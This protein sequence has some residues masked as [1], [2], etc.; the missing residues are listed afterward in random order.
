MTSKR[1]RDAE[2]ETVHVRQLMCI[3]SISERIARK[4]LARFG[5]V[6]A[7][8]CAL[9]EPGDFPRVQLDDRTTLGRARL[10]KL[11]CYLT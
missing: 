1:K 5:N 10:A 9:L 8:Q 7:L 4:L 3:P 2:L 6:P 11:R